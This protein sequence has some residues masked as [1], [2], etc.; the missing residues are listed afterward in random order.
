MPSVSIIDSHVHL[1]DTNRLSYGWLERR[2]GINHPHL[3]PDYERA[4]EGLAIDKIVFAEVWVDAP[5][6]VAEAEWLSQ[7]AALHPA[8]A[9]MIA[10]A[11]LEIGREVLADIEKMRSLPT[12]RAIRRI[13]EAETDER[14]CERPGFVDAVRLLG[15][16]D[17]VCDICVFAHQLPGVVSL[18]QQCPETTIVLDHIGKPAIR[19]GEIDGWRSSITELSALPNVVTKVSGVLTE[20]DQGNWSREIIRPY[21]DHAIESFGFDRVM[22]GSDWPVL[23]LTTSVQNWVDIVDWAIHGSSKEEQ[24]K[25]YR[26]N[27][28]RIYK[29]A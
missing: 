29:L 17:V 18:A 24:S 11:P 19:S 23:A 8:I 13:T 1:F 3:F 28:A 2:P 26:D 14:F 25:L 22:F 9:G 21:L 27:A 6:H 10:A 15:E 5:L 4:V 7:Q 12:F 16:I 20:A